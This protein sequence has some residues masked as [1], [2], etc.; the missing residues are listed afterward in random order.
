MC[1]RIFDVID[2]RGIFRV[3]HDAALP[4]LSMRDAGKVQTFDEAW[5]K[6]GDD[7][8]SHVCT[9]ATCAELDATDRLQ[10]AS[11]APLRIVPFADNLIAPQVLCF[12]R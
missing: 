10:C 11:T 5:G 7:R 9:W 6:M 4:A 1:V 8:I 2:E 12:V 3:V